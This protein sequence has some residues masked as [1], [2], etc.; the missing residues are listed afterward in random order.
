MADAIDTDSAID[1]DAPGALVSD[2]QFPWAAG[3]HFSQAVRAGDVIVTAGQAG[4]DDHGQF[5]GDDFEAQ[6]RQAFR[7][8]DRVLRTQGSSLDGIMRLNTYLSDQSQYEAFKR[9]RGEFLTVP[10]PASTAVVVGFVFPG[11]LCEI[12]AIAVRG[13]VR[14][15]DPEATS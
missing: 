11:M 5:V 6:F 8:L 12:E 1:T 13:G 4:F 7:N 10:Y 3:W 2:F 9:I 15:R 14:R